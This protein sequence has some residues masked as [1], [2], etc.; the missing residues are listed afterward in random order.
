MTPLKT[1]ILCKPYPSDEMSIG[2]IIVPE[3]ARGVSNK[4]LIV[5][6]GSGTKEKPMHLKEGDT[7]HRVRDWGCEVMIDGELHFL[8]DQ[9]A[10]IATTD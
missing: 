4:V 8:M 9:E 1:Q 7:G 3:T 6:V 5:K 2:G 10:I